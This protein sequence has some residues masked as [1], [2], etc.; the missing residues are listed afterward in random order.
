MKNHKIRPLKDPPQAI[1]EK[2]EAKKCYI[3]NAMNLLVCAMRYHFYNVLV[4]K[5]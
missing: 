5:R 3:G 2:K 4:Y 1:I